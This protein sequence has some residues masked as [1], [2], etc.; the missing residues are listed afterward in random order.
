MSAG[1]KRLAER[2]LGRKLRDDC[3][4]CGEHITY[5]DDPEGVWAECGC[6]AG[7]LY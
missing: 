5:T 4:H 2:Q 7:Y 3:R 1:A 6:D